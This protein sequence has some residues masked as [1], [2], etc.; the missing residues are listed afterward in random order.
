MYG[1]IIGDVIGS[2]Y[3]FNN[4]KTKDF[5]LFDSHSTFTDDSVMTIAVAKALI[6]ARDEERSFKDLLKNNDERVWESISSCRLWR[7]VFSMACRRF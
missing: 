6:K 5:S 7:N 1:A 4:I 2:V 3:E